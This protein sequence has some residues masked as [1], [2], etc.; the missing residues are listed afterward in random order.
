LLSVLGEDESAGEMIELL[1]ENRI[2]V[3]YLMQ[4]DQRIT[5]TKTRIISRNQ[6]ILRL[7]HEITDDLSSDLDEKF[8]NHVAQFIEQVQPH[9]LIFEDYNKGVITESVIKR[10]IEL[11]KS[12]NILTAVDPKKKNFFAYQGVDIFKPNLKEVREALLIHSEEVSLLG[13]ENIH[14][15]LKT[16]LNH[17]ISF[18]TLSEKGVFFQDQNASALLPTHVR[19]IA[20]VSGAGDT[21]IAVAS[22]VYAITKDPRLMA[23]MA[24]L[25]GGLVCEEVGTVSI[26]K[27]RLLKEC[28]TL[29]A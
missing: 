22:L 11:C 4:N 7:D 14:Q 28:L 18:I 17:E 26:N 2:N 24:N 12:K 20:D 9:V 25:A 1:K 15:L 29:S 6:H 16:K 13:M 5:T 27:E 8:I 23:Q 10:V 3:D 21:V 19:K